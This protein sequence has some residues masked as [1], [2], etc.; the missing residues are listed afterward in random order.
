MV[1]L[2]VCATLFCRGFA[3]AVRRCVQ[4]NAPH[5]ELGRLVV[6]PGGRRWSGDLTRRVNQNTK[7][8]FRGFASE[9][10]MLVPALLVVSSMVLRPQGLME[11]HI[12]CLEM[13][14]TIQCLIMPG[15]TAL[16]HLDFLEQL[17]DAHHQLYMMLYPLCQ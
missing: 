4:W 2:C 15:N 14:Y 3:R 1:V 8:H 11:A 13:M 17:L 6:L 5:Q 16:P 7:A 12:T 10:L 9:V